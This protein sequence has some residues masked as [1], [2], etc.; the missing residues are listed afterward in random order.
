M[1]LGADRMGRIFDNTEAIGQ[2]K[3]FDLSHI[4]RVA[5]EVNGDQNLG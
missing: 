1:M 3:L 2:A 4:A 5:A